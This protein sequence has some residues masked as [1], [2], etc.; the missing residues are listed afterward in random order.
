[1]ASNYS[2]TELFG[3]GS[4]LKEN[5]TAGVENTIC[6]TKVVLPSSFRA[7]NGDVI[8]TTR[9]SSNYL[10]METRTTLI[11]LFLYIFLGVFSLVLMY[12]VVKQIIILKVFMFQ[13]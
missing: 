5:F 3:T 4:F 8:D 1:M 10:F 7:D 11:H 13:P 2:P 12:T 6:L 9:T